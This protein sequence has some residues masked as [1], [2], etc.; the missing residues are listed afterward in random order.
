MEIAQLLVER[1]LL[2][3]GENVL[4]LQ[5]VL[6]HSGTVLYIEFRLT[7]QQEGGGKGEARECEQGVSLGFREREQGVLCLSRCR[8]VKCARPEHGPGLESR[9]VYYLVSSVHCI[10][11]RVQGVGQALMQ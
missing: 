3:G 11:C 4:H 5:R 7:A 9:S 2:V 6:V 10:G 8:F 1:T